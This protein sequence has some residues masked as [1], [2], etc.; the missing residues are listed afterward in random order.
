MIWRYRF[1]HFLFFAAFLCVI[2][3]LFYWQIVR[4]EELS[5]LGQLQ[6]GRKVKVLSSRGEIKTSD[7][8][9]IASNTL[10]FLVF[11]NPKQI[12]DKAKTIDALAS[13]L[14]LEKASISASLTQN[15]LWVPL[16]IVNIETKNNI[17]KLQLE[18]VG[19]EKQYSRLYPEAS[20]SAQVLG[21]VGKNELGEDKGYFGLEG[22][23]DRQLKAKGGYTVEVFDAI[24]RPILAKMQEESSDSN[25]RSLLL[26]INRAIQFLVEEKLKKGIEKY[27]AAGGMAAVMDPKTGSILAMVSYPSFDP[28]NYQDYDQS[29]FVNPLISRIYEPGST[30]KT[31]VMSAAIDA[32]V[33]TPQTRCPICSG[34][35]P[36]AEYEIKTW[37]NKYYSNTTMTEV[38]QHS[39]NIGM[40]YVG[41]SL[42]VDKMISYLKAFG[43]GELTGI[44]LQGEV[45]S[46]MRS[47]DAWSIIDL[48]TASFGQGIS[49][50]PIS[51]LNAFSSIA[52][53]GV[54]M[55]P[56]VVSKITIPDE[57]TISIAPKVMGQPISP[58]TAK[59]MTEIFVNAVNNGEAKYYKP[60]GYRIA[61]KT[62][63][64]QIPIAGHYDPNKTIASFIGFGPADD[65]KFSMIVI[66]DRPT[67]SIYGSETAV[68]VFMEI[69][70]DILAY[71]GIPPLE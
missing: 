22:Y 66:I 29:T 56:Q 44:D 9:P 25:G 49:V 40:V 62:G 39:D 61:G 63:T 53:K 13:F 38:I 50:T 58:Q 24:G 69:A 6:Y 65:P 67:T 36:I 59:I 30:F 51:L 37:N 52:N 47:K 14:T 26:H 16:S 70:K 71:Y 10:S 23:Y 35:I 55:Q 18:G 60:K 5:S 28:K 64:A 1:L 31:L 7:N 45:V 41:Q 17:E 11:A 48:A 21:F 57:Q 8:F 20:S 3:R 34:P 46:Q 27:Q 2:V 15:L 68:P 42:G 19:F 43:I 4:A 54:L 32:K 33:V 12:K